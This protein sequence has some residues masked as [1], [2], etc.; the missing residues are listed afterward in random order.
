MSGL[1]HLTTV[2]PG[3][4][5]LEGESGGR[6]PRSNSFV[7]R[8]S[9]DVLVDA[10]CGPSRL[11]ELT[12]TW[13]PD[14]LVVSHSHP[15][16]CSSAWQL[17]GTRIL[18]PAQ[19]SESFW[20]FET[21][22]VRFAG[23][24]A[25]QWIRFVTEHMGIREFDADAHFDDG[26]VFDFGAIS[27]VCLHAPGHAED[28]YVFFEPHHGIAMTFD[29]D[30]SGFGPWYGHVESDIDLFLTSIDK[31][32]DLQPRVLLSSHKGMITH[33]IEGRLRRF[34][35]VVEERDDRILALLHRPR[36]VSE[37]LDDSPIYG[38]HPYPE[39]PLDYWEGQ[40]IEKHLERLTRHGLAVEVSCSTRES[41]AEVR[42]VATHQ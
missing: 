32:M 13:R 11:A 38:G 7:I 9:T 15:D 29:I 19:R 35:A 14:V 1:P 24:S 41:P 16:H 40:M 5:I 42:W 23:T 12:A 33:D 26:T 28:H 37:L 34:A 18:S 30:L 4:E 10:G 21:Q 39:M 8:G 36:T 17:E 27:L 31:V 2:V 6:F 20:R 25:Q 22:S 3:L